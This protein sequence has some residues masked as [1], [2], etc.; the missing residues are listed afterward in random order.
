MKR[1]LFTLL[2]VFIAT[3]IAN[4]QIIEPVKWSF[5]SK[6]NGKEVELNFIATIEEKWHLYDTYLPEGGPIATEIVFDDSTLFIKTG[7]L[8][9]DPLPVEKFDNAFQLNVRYFSNKVTLTQ[10]IQLPTD[11]PVEINGYVL[12][13]SCDDETVCLPTKPAFH[14]V[15]TRVAALR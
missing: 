6:Q 4:S 5:D 12:F 13:M 3:L 11:E 2:L 9:K 15:L 10:K 14:L 1:L 8:L 7:E